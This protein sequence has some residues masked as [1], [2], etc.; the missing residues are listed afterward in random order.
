M[1]IEKERNSAKTASS[2]FINYDAAKGRRAL[3]RILRKGK[4]QIR[5]GKYGTGATRNNNRRFDVR[6]EKDRVS[7]KRGPLK[8]DESETISSRRYAPI[9]RARL[10]SAGYRLPPGWPPF[11]R[12]TH[13][14]I[15]RP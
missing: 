12:A 3:R 6:K 11:R 9:L 2:F 10:R 8:P 7:T 13:R 4:R 14:R 15:H 5:F 1:S